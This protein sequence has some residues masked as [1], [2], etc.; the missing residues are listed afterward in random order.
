MTAQKGWGERVLWEKDVGPVMSGN[1]C[2]EG[3]CGE[4][5]CRKGTVEKRNAGRGLWRK[6]ECRKNHPG[7]GGGDVDK[8]DAG[9]GLW[10]KGMQEGDCG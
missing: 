3:D 1:I 8:R 7:G 2:E 6:G 4:K 5:E 10:I 9:R